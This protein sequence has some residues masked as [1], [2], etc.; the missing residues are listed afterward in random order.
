MWTCYDGLICESFD[1]C[2]ASTYPLF[3]DNQWGGKF[4][5]TSDNGYVLMVEYSEGEECW[6]DSEGYLYESI[7]NFLADGSHLG[8]GA[9]RVTI[10]VDGEGGPAEFY[11][12]ARAD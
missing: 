8:E 12:T 9:T 5:L 7:D 4:T 2:F 6:I 11:L 1:D 3:L 10:L